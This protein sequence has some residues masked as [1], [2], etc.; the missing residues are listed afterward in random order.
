M[1]KTNTIE[2]NIEF[3]ISMYERELERSDKDNRTQEE[4]EM[5][6]SYLIELKTIIELSK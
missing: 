3:L 4:I 1:K 2:E 6:E 5:I